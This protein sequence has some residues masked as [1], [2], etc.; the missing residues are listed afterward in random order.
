MSDFEVRIDLNSVSYVV[1]ADTKEEAIGK[2]NAIA[3]QETQHDL[4]K[5]AIYNATKLEVDE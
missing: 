3:L 2:A 1:Q 5:W 4:L